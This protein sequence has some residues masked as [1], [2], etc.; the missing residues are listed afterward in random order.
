M[1][2]P[3]S[4]AFAEA[5][6]VPFEQVVSEYGLRLNDY[7]DRLGIE[8]A[9]MLC[10]DLGGTLYSSRHRVIDLAG[11]ADREIAQRRNHEPKVLRDYVLTTLKPT[12]IHV[13]GSWA[14]SVHLHHDPRFAAAH[15]PI[16][17]TPV[18]TDAQT[19]RPRYYNGEWVRRDA[20]DDPAK[21]EALQQW[22]QT[23]PPLPTLRDPGVV[24]FPGD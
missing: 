20:V 19:G 6:T 11:L 22:M 9:T 21:L 24:A 12:F 14:Q 8:G 2:W 18:G 1:H 3:C 4:R 23:N 16:T 10:P 5:P 17:A 7:A 15:A 13:H